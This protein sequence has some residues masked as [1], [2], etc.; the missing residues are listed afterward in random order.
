MAPDTVTF[1][2][3]A[4]Y[5]PYVSLVGDFNGWDTRANPLVTDG[6]G[7]WWMTMAHPGPTRYGYFVAIDEQSHTWVGDPYATQL[8]WDDDAPW[9]YLPSDR[10]RLRVDGSA[11]A[12][13]GPAR[14]GDLR[15]E[16]T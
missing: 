1:A 3:R 5:K 6:R 10:N 2:L 9:A 7:T 15:V 4:P 12:N 16:C 13:A 8:R 14:H 11:L